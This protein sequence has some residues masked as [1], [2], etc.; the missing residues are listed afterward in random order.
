[1]PRTIRKE[2]LKSL[3]VDF[4]NGIFKLNG[5]DMGDITELNLSFS[6]RGDWRLLVER[7][8]CYTNSP[9]EED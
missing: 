3:T 7:S 6:S 5:E 4:E 9:H 8:E 1:M 2:I